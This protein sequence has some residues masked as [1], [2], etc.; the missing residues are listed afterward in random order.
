MAHARPLATIALGRLPRGAEVEVLRA[1]SAALE[2]PKGARGIPFIFLAGGANDSAADQRVCGI[3]CAPRIAPIAV[4]RG[5]RFNLGDDD[6]ALEC[7]VLG[8]REVGVFDIDDAKFG[9]ET[10]RHTWSKVKA[11]RMSEKS[12]TLGLAGG[13]LAWIALDPP[14][15]EELAAALALFK[16]LELPVPA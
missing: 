10:A 2:L 15:K 3:A 14:P 11:A 8:E 9:T 1:A 16:R 6:N 7:I 4:F 12:L 5:H 13:A